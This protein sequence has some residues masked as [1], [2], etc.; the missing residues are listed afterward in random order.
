MKLSSSAIA[1][2][3]FSVSTHAFVSSPSRLGCKHANTADGAIRLQSGLILRSTVEEEEDVAATAG[4]EKPVGL[5]AE[6]AD[7]TQSSL[8]NGTSLVDAEDQKPGMAENAKFQCEESVEF[9]QEFQRDGFWSAQENLRE[10]GNVGTRFAQMG[11]EAL[12][13]WLVSC[14]F[15]FSAIQQLD[16]LFMFKWSS[17]YLVSLIS[18]NLLV[19]V[20]PMTDR[21]TLAVRD[22]LVSMHCSEMLA[23]NCMS[24]WSTIKKCPSRVRCHLIW[25]PR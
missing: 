15:S 4:E 8:E 3:A 13:H 11:P 9:W 7:A 19:Y 14:L 17:H 10:L 25:I 12:S 6:G 16:V 24:A 1:L 23:F 21:D 18:M 2:V 5:Q 20:Y 22:T